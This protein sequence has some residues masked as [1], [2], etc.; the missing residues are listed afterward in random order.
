MATISQNDGHR[1]IHDESVQKFGD[2]I[3]VGFK[4]D[5]APVVLRGT[6]TEILGMLERICR[7]IK[8]HARHTMKNARDYREEMYA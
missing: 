3:M 1:D 6:S 5:R 8:T 2:E 4:T 7:E